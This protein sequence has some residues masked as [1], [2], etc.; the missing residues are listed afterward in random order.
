MG[1]VG[2]PL[3]GRQRKSSAKKR[4]SANKKTRKGGQ[5]G[6]G[7][8]PSGVMLNNFFP[9]LNQEQPEDIQAMQLQ[10]AML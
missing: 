7:N 5:P 8:Q 9:V 4:T 10:Q 1:N 6:Q 2:G 3:S